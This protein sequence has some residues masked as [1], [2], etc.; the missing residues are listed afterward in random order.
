M[1][2]ADRL[3]VVALE[4]AVKEQQGRLVAIERS[5]AWRAGGALQ[6]LFYS[7]LRAGPR[8]VVL[9]LRL[10]MRRR[11]RPTLPADPFR[12]QC[13][14]GEAGKAEYVIYGDRPAG[15]ELSDSS[16]QTNDPQ[17]LLHCLELIDEPGCLVLRRVDAIVIRRIGYLREQG[18]RLIWWPEEPCCVPVPW[19]RYVAGLADKT[20]I[21]ARQ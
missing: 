3:I 5:S 1:Q 20:R 2:H 4:H 14:Q 10:F 11:G 8:A 9:L 15:L 17:L 7:P 18:W 13:A 16:W 21:A 12:R 6:D 19:V